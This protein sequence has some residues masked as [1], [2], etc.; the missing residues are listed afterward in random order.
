MKGIEFGSDFEIYQ[1]VLLDNAQ[2]GKV[3]TFSRKCMKNIHSKPAL[4]TF[5]SQVEFDPLTAL[6]SITY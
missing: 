5:L 4:S 3:L 6:T 2:K 1:C